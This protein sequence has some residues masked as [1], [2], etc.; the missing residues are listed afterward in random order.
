VPQSLLE[1]PRLGAVNIHASLLPRW[2][3]AAPIQRAI[4]AGDAETGITIMQMDAGLD[5]GAML[6]Q[7][8]VAI[9]ADDTAQTLH[10]KLAALG[11]RLIVDALSRQP[12]PRSQDAAH[13]TYARKIDKHE[14]RI[15]WTEDAAGIE[16]KV[17]AFNPIPGAVSTL[18]GV[19]VKIWRARVEP[20]IVA[21]PG[22]VCAADAAGMVV[23]CGRDGLR[24]LELQ[25]AGGKRLPVSA[26]I[27]GFQ[28]M[29]GAHFGD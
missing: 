3:G 11:G 29:C 13:A 1:A 21:E 26:F 27:S 5:T 8:A 2:R 15:V 7:E 12:A 16:R 14:A 19:D 25:R 4:L 20:G 22:T 9:S 6:L 18:G 24:L 23:A 17:R 28:V 10:D